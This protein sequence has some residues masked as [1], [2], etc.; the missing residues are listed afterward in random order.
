MMRHMRSRTMLPDRQ[1][2]RRRECARME[3]HVGTPGCGNAPRRRYH[4]MVWGDLAKPRE[5]SWKQHVSTC[6]HFHGSHSYCL[7]RLGFGTYSP[8]PLFAIVEPSPERCFFNALGERGLDRCGE[9]DDCLERGERFPN[10]DRAG[11]SME[12]RAQ[13]QTGRFLCRKNV[14]CFL[15]SHAWPSAPQFASRQNDDVC[16]TQPLEVAISKVLLRVKK[17]KNAWGEEATQS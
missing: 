10:G 3:E 1:M 13:K 2:K 12:N 11:C 5:F 15:A 14:R 17:L 7:G 8:L 9:R 6:T 16:A 4:T